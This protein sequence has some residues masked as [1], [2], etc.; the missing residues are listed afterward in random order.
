MGSV[1]LFLALG[2]TMLATRKLNWY[3]LGGQTSESTE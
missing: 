1:L 2:T 3:G